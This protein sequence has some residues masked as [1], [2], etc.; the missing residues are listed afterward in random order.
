MNAAPARAKKR[1][2]S[3]LGAHRLSP[4][5]RT[6]V[7]LGGEP[8]D[9][10]DPSND[11]DQANQQPPAALPNVMHASNPERNPW[12]ERGDP[13]ERLQQVAREEH[14]EHPRRR[15]RNGGEEHEPPVLRPTRP[16][17]DLRIRPRG[18]VALNRLCELHLTPPQQGSNAAALL[19]CTPQPPAVARLV[20]GAAPPMFPWRRRQSLPPIP[21]IATLLA[22]PKGQVPRWRA[23]K[24]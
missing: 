15:T 22:P 14:I 18:H 3:A 24:R 12:D 9:Q 2:S 20:T 11:R 21:L 16:P 13:E 7:A 8:D 19:N 17:R 4:L 23:D 10:H 5:V 1:R 6:G